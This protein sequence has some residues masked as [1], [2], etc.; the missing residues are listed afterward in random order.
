MVCGETVGAKTFA[1]RIA[2]RVANKVATSSANFSAIRL[3]V[4][5]AILF[6]QVVDVRESAPCSAP[7]CIARETTRRR[8]RP[9][10][11]NDL[12]RGVGHGS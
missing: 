5:L 1:I 4:S 10:S 3:A 6:L 8:A 7:I 2:N 12:G 11:P 9:L